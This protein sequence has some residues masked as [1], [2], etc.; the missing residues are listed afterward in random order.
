[1]CLFLMFILLV[2]MTCF[3]TWIIFRV[4]VLS[5]L[6]E[7]QSDEVDDAQK[8]ISELEKKGQD[9]KELSRKIKERQNVFDNR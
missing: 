7:K 5:L 1:M 3:K 9:L 8:K 4:K 6:K 2:S